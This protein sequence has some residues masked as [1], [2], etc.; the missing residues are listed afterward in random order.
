MSM[1]Y[2]PTWTDI[3]IRLA[4]TFIAGAVLGFDREATGHPAGLRTT[5]L[6]ALA[7]A[8]A[9]V[10]CNLLLSL[11]GKNSGSF[12]VM[13]LM[14]LP[15]G[16]LTGVGFIGGGTIL[17][18][19]D[20]ITGITTAA[21]LWI[22]TVIGL[23]FGGGQLELGAIS[24]LLAAMT[25]WGV[26]L[27]DNR[28]PRKQH[29]TV[30]ILASAGPSSVSKFT[31]LVEPLGFR[32]DFYRQAHYE[33]SKDARLCFQISWKRPEAAGIP[34]DLLAVINGHY[35]LLDIELEAPARHRI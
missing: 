27:L 22:A 8:I 25:L 28:L 3:G 9:M 12:A 5:I 15:L 26:K 1:P 16:I 11:E 18:R 13:D 19:G 17:K 10:Q 29:A 34:E 24:T 4:L 21:T 35:L 7:A 31:E 30:E 2:S 23:C 20:L 6:V 14:R 33:D 32:A